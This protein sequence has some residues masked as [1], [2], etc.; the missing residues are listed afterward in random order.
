MYKEYM[1][2]N[3][4][5][6]INYS[7]LVLTYNMK[8]R[9]NNFDF[10]DNLIEINTYIVFSTAYSTSLQIITVLFVNKL[11]FKPY[12]KCYSSHAFFNT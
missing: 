7:Q 8:Q 6:Q 9:T 1:I 11:K 2:L 10:D 12:I 5:L 4:I 3:N